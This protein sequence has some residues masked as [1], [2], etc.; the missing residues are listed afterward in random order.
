MAPDLPAS[1]VLLGLVAHHLARADADPFGNPVLSV[2]LAITRM[3]DEDRLALPQIAAAVRELRDLAFA[4]RARR[5]ARY[6]GGTDEAANTAAL[7]AVARNVLRPDPADSPVPWARFRECVERPRYAAVFTAHPTFALSPET[8][9]ALAE[10]A[11]GAPA[12]PPPLGSHRRDLAWPRRARPAERRAAG[13]RPRRMARSLD[14]TRAAPGDPGELGRLRHR[15]PHR[16]HL[17]RHAPPAP[18]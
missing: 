4:A 13:V 2:S 6:V 15:R 17:G 1:S 7:A 11:C 16:H 18:A 10:A 9:A 12:P 14:R 5:L 8:Y 3:M